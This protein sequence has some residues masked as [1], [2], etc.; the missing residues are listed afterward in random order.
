MKRLIV[1]RAT[2]IPTWLFCL[3]FI[4]TF[5]NAPVLANER[6][7][8]DD[9]DHLVPIDGLLEPA[10]Q[11]LLSKKLFVTP[12]NFT[13]IAI[14]P[15]AASK[16]EVAIALYSKPTTKSEEN[17]F[18]TCTKAEKNLWYAASNENGVLSKDTSVEIARFDAPFP[19]S[20]AMTIVKGVRRM[21]AQRQ[22]PTKTNKVIV[23]GTDI[24]VSI[25]DGT[26]RPVQG[27]LTPYAR[28]NNGSAL[29][30]L[31]DM[32]EI[33]CENRTVNRERLIKKIEAEASRL[34][35]SASSPKSAITPEGKN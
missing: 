6:A 2:E 17:V 20:V 13:R 27:L 1:R 5:A 33:Y 14:L 4:A 10:Y 30:R 31:A 32:L 11:A 7:K 12:G 21:L 35:E 26:S 9:S 18:I 3:C 29:R 24:E 16:G 15:S 19:K 34:A 8:S 22:P 25:D 23:D 28:G